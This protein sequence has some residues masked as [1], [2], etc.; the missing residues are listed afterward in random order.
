VPI[1]A[2]CVFVVGVEGVPAVLARFDTDDV[3]S[4]VWRAAGPYRF[5][6]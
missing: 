1:A 2:L 3:V 6:V 4:I 5:G